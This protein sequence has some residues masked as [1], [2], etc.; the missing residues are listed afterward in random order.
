LRRKKPNSELLEEI[1][2]DPT[3]QACED[4]DRLVKISLRDLS[5]EERINEASKPLYL[6]RYE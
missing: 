6:R 4:I 5:H 2:T 3:A 1:E